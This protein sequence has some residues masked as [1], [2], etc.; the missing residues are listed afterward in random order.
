M[1]KF[2]R[3]HFEVKE[4]SDSEHYGK[5]VFDLWKRVWI[6]YWECTKTCFA[7]LFTGSCRILKL[8]LMECTMSSLLFQELLKTLRQ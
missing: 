6:Y 2:E 5:F 3:A 4:Y 8:R 7:L 1:Q